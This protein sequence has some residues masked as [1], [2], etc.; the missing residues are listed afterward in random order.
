MANSE[1]DDPSLR[2][3]AVVGAGRGGLIVAMG[4]VGWLGWGLGEAKLF[5]PVVGTAF[6]FMALLLWAWSIFTIRKGR[7]LRRQYSPGAS[8]S[9]RAVWRSFFVVVLLE[10]LGIACAFMLAN[11]IHRPDLW[12]DWCALVV[13]LHFLPLAKIFRAPILGV[14]GVSISLWCVLCWVLFRSDGLV[15]SVALGTGI[16]LCAASAAASL[17][18]RR[19]AQSLA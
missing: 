12:A 2:A 17:R 1:K 4:G 18:G 11:R 13:G 10:V 9:R 6:G 5:S 7:I 15:I 19:I 8:S 16:L 3:E 14:L